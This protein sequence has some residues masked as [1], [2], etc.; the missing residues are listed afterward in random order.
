MA[1][2]A[3]IIEAAPTPRPVCFGCGAPREATYR[4]VDEHGQ[5][6]WGA[7]AVARVFSGWKGYGRFHS[8]ECATRYANWVAREKGIKLVITNGGPP[9]GDDSNAGGP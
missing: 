4:T 8:Q 2:L 9:A 5:S 1:K 3:P 7:N 6:A